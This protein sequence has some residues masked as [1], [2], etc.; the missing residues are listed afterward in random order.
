MDTNTNT[1]TPAARW[2]PTSQEW[3]LAAYAE[4]KTKFADLIMGSDQPRAQAYALWALCHDPALDGRELSNFRNGCGNDQ[5]SSEHIERARSAHKPL[6][7]KQSPA[8]DSKDPASKAPT[9]PKKKGSSPRKGGKQL[10]KME[11]AILANFSDASELISSFKA[12]KKAVEKARK[13]LASAAEELRGIDREKA[14]LLSELDSQA[15]A[16]LKEL[17]LLG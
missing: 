10:S 6:E 3:G 9:A 16:V 11:R 8:T 1:S 7:D 14:R 2:K 4:T 12:A 5:P 15:A 13:D 17:G